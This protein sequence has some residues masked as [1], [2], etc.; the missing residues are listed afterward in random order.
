MSEPFLGEIRAFPMNYAPQGWMQCNGAEL[1]INQNQA[2]YAILG[3]TYGG[4]GTTTFAVPDL[5]GRTPVHC[6]NGVMFG[7][8]AGEET[9]TLTV[10][11]MPQHTHMISANSENGNNV[12]A[13]GNIWSN[14]G[15][16]Q[17]YS[18][19]TNAIMSGNAL[20]TAGQSQAHNN[21]QP[22]NVINYCIAIVGIFPT[23]N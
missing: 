7:E 2:L 20:S 3:T 22:Y 12:S 4:N 15:Q 18:P 11:E 13:N 23:Q 10:P 16:M 19:Q 17:A 21:M 8:S 9:H 1:Q 6:G 5:R 14:T